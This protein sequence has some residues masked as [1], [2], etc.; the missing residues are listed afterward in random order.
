MIGASVVSFLAVALA[1]AREAAAAAFFGMLGPLVMAGVSW[2]VM[3]RTYRRNPERL[4]AVMVGGFGVKMLLVGLYLVV[5][6]RAVNLS[7]TPFVASFTSYFVLLYV[8]E[9]LYLRRLFAGPPQQG[10]R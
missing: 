5:M 2:M 4:T 8:I 10:S 1:L 6:L 7:P 9:A 3:E